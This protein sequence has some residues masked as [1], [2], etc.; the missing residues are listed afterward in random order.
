M[1]PDD[2]KPF[3]DTFEI[4]TQIDAYNKGDR[5][6]SV[7]TRQ[8]GDDGIYRRVESTNYYVKNPAS[9][10]ILSITLSKALE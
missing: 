7:I 1:H 2:R 3:S 5:T 8:L 9:D 6:R 10:D 4:H